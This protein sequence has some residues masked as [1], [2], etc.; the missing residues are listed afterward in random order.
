M[1][2]DRLFEV[3]WGLFLSM[4]GLIVLGLVMIFSSS[5]IPA[6]RMMDSTPYFFQKQLVWSLIGMVGCFAAAWVSP[7]TLKQVT[8]VIYAGSVAL[9][10]LVLI[11]FIGR[12]AGG[13][14]RWL[15]LG[16]IGMQP[17]ELSKIAVIMT[18]GL[19]LSKVEFREKFMI[20]HIVMVMFITL[21][22]AILIALEPDVGTAFQVFTLGLIMLF[23]AGFPYHYLLFLVALSVPV[24]AFVIFTSGYRR[25]RIVAYMNPWGDP[26]DKGYHTI[27]SMKALAAGGFTGQGLGESIRKLGY[28]PEPFTDTIV[29]IMA[30][31]LGFISV[32]LL[33][34]LL[35]FLVVRGFM[36]SLQTSDVF[37]RF[38]G[39]GLTS[40]IAMQA[41]LNLSVVSGLI[42]TTGVSMPFISYGGSALVINMTAV[43]LIMNISRSSIQ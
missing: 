8:P 28:L 5:A 42:P 39:I 26:L 9:L 25:A 24:G 12:E 37:F 19:Y 38:I 23:L 15:D 1:S 13:A 2:T 10:A 32:L 43:G 6:Y 21:L 11:P 3:D 34:G 30:E 40:L 14:R 20:K 4:L 31:E 36:I 27:Q 41:A 29:A 35:G 22:P 17:S 18:A 33:I 7:V 16:I